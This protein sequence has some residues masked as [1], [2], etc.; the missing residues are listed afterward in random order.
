MRALKALATAVAL[1]VSAVSVA[2][3]LPVAAVAQTTLQAQLQ[4][5]V[6][7]LPANATQAQV[8]AAINTI[9]LASQ[10]T[11]AQKQAAVNGVV[12]TPNNP[13]VGVV[14]N[15]TS[16]ALGILAQTPP[17]TSQAAINQAI[18][19]GTATLSAGARQAAL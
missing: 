4:L 14:L 5:A 17:G 9:L 7:G 13:N 19:D 11:A 18:A 3:L 16:I 2:A 1:S 10:A 6:D 12:P 8:A 15:G